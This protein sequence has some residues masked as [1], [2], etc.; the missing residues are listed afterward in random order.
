MAVAS[1]SCSMVLLC[2]G[3]HSEAAGRLRAGS[4]AAA[5][6]RRTTLQ[7]LLDRYCVTCHNGRTQTAG[8]ALDQLDVERLGTNAA[9]WEK[10]VRKLRTGAMPPVGMPR[11]PSSAYDDLIDWLETELDRGAAAN[12]NPG[13][14]L[15]RRLNRAEYTNTV[16]DLLGVEIDGK[17]FL[18]ADNSGFG[19]DNI[20]DVLTL[21]PALLDRYLIVAQM[22]SRLA[23]S[24][25]SIQ[26]T[27]A[28]YR[29][30]FELLQEERMDDD[31]PF[32]SRGGFAIR[33]YFPA[34]GEYE[35]KVTLQTSSMQNTPRG[36]DAMNQLDVRLDGVRLKLFTIG[37]QPTAS[38][39]YDT[40]QRPEERISVRLPVV[41]GQ[42]VIG[43]A[44]QNR[45]WVPEGVGPAHMPATSYSYRHA[46]GTNVSFGRIEMAVDSVD[47]IGPYNA[48]RAAGTPTRHQVFICRPSSLRDEESCARRILARLAR[49][50]YRREVSDSEVQTLVDF[51]KTGR[52]EVSFERGIQRAIERLL[53]SPDFL[54]RVEADQR[55]TGPAY[56]ISDTEL[57]TRLSLFL[58][59]SIPDD[60]LL[61]L[62][63]K[64]RLRDPRI[65]DQQVRRMLKD[66]RSKA[67]IDNFFGQWLWL[68]NVALK[69][70]DPKAF[71]DFDENL[72]AGFQRE[73]ELFF[74]SQIREDRSALELLTA[75]Y[76]FV[77]ER[78]ARH[79]GIPNIYGSRFRRVT[80]PDERRAGILGLGG[81]LMVTSYDHRTS[82]VVRG[83]WLLE[84]LLG[85]PPPPPPANVPPF[86]EAEEG[87]ATLVSV[88]ERMEVHRRNPVCASCHSQL[89]PLGFALEN[90]D[91]IGKWREV[92]GV[93]KINASGNMPN[94]AK[95]NGPAEF[96]AVLVEQSDAFMRTLVEKLVTYALGRGVEYYDMPAVRRIL[97]ESATDE[98]RWS[99]L[100]LAI[101]KSAPFRM[102][103]SAS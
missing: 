69:R 51:Y 82:P 64:G 102:R 33:H 14:P 37:G 17:G 35:I 92:D 48:K 54:F 7:A 89:D 46:T 3:T 1:L 71:Q 31:L 8:L 81:I 95:F 11:P 2:G 52:D 91:G 90:F 56:Y 74:Q 24:D 41:A 96:R 21:S 93:T 101:V 28:N 19:F 73:A 4:Q 23:V 13:R 25:P 53:V 84:N 40:T 61:D 78:L 32:G 83:K 34:D 94:G 9:T 5:S 87:Q 63:R 16:R 100:L 67:F 29:L 103:G 27:I 97:R 6:P 80:F 88:R 76:T 26:A 57:A 86:P 20:G 50:A 22:A 65:L 12:P 43:I 15:V 98:Y 10:V 62:A 66:L 59:S 55:G 75:N 47:I 60:Q 70:P 58:W 68:R 49:R 39:P 44:F 42:R 77:N 72:R 85:T 79:Y 45:K 38:G 36:M 30:P 18:P 99:S